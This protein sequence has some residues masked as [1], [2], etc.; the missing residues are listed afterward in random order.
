MIIDLLTIFGKRQK[1]PAS[2]V[3]HCPTL[4]DGQISWRCFLCR[5]LATWSVLVQQSDRSRLRA[6]YPFP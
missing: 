4:S 5:P 1:P 2:G 6:I 3:V